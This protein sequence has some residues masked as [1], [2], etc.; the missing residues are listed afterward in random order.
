M[1]PAPIRLPISYTP[2]RVPAA[3]A[4]LSSGSWFQQRGPIEQHG[5]GI[6]RSLGRVALRVDQEPCA[7]PRDVIAK[8]PVRKRAARRQPG[9]KQLFWRGKREFGPDRYGDGH[10][11]L[12]G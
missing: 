8:H 1:P 7:V 4:I 11:L 5:D 9:L 3:N 6:R 2:S 12:V 10:Q